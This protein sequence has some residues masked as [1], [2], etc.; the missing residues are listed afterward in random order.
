[1]LV[2]AIDAITSV[3]F[4]GSIPSLDIL[5]T[6]PYPIVPHRTP[7]HRTVPQPHPAYLGVDGGADGIAEDEHKLPTDIVSLGGQHTVVPGRSD[8]H[9]VLDELDV[10]LAGYGGEE[11][12]GE[13]MRL[14]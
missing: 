13:M 2:V 11:G 9:Q 1:M 6:P 4:C 10:A 14:D 5:S 3:S 12:G 8:V 7:P